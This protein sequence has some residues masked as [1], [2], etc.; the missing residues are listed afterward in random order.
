LEG[1]FVLSVV[2][3]CIHRS[4]G[5]VMSSF[6]SMSPTLPP[7]TWGLHGNAPSDECSDGFFRHCTGTNV[8]SQRNYAIDSLVTP[9]FGTA[10]AG[11]NDT[12]AEAF[13]RQLYLSMIAQVIRRHDSLPVV[14]LF[15]HFLVLQRKKPTLCASS[16][17]QALIVKSAVEV[18]RS[19]N[20]WGTLL[21]QL[22]EM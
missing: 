21:W 14:P 1:F 18:Q 10:V 19:Q 5:V 3:Y 22:N 16:L 7:E 2:E 11:V 9:Y 8:M 13:A 12:G 4:V 6:E 17:M 20:T 15:L